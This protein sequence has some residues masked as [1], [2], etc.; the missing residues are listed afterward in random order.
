M[1]TGLMRSGIIDLKWRR[2]KAWRDHLSEIG[3]AVLVSG[4]LDTGDRRENLVV[5][6]P[7]ARAAPLDPTGKDRG[8]AD[9]LER[10]L[11]GV[12]RLN[13]GHRAGELHRNAE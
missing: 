12:G 11:V 6:L 5:D 7:A 9:L 13:D 4:I 3:N 1:T 2:R 8:L 10:G